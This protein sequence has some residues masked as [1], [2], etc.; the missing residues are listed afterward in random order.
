MA[1]FSVPDLTDVILERAAAV[2]VPIV[3]ESLVD[4]QAEVVLA[5]RALISVVRLI[6]VP[7]VVRHW[8][9]C[10]HPLERASVTVT[11]SR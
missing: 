7:L 8:T 11:F 4:L 9:T 3:V 10:G 5:P 1:A 2:V 6:P